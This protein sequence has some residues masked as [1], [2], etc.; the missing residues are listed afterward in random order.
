MRL[1]SSYYYSYP[2]IIIMTIIILIRNPRHTPCGPP[3]V[4]TNSAAVVPHIGQTRLHPENPECITTPACGGSNLCSAPVQ[5][6]DMSIQLVCCKILPI[7]VYI[8]VIL[9]LNQFN[10]K[11]IFLLLRV[12]PKICC[13]PYRPSCCSSILPFPLNLQPQHVDAGCPRGVR[14]SY[15]RPHCHSPAPTI[16]TSRSAP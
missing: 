15:R 7:V 14:S 13:V 8:A 9:L 1:L 4:F 2:L 3:S 10:Y 16:T 12:R 6:A 11:V 5:T